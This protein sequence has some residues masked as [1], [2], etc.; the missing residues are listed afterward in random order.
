MYSELLTGKCIKDLIWSQKAELPWENHAQISPNQ[1]IQ[2]QV[3]YQEDWK[4]W[5]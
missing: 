3:P 2:S 1:P 5:E 4:T